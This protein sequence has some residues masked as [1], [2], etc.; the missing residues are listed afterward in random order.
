MGEGP[1]PRP[2]TP[3]HNKQYYV[4]ITHVRHVHLEQHE[5]LLV[6][7]LEGGEHVGVVL[8]PAPVHLGAGVQGELHGQHGV[9]AVSQG[10]HSCGGK[11]G[12][13]QVIQLHLARLEMRLPFFVNYSA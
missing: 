2:D 10:D 11:H 9:L 1:G 12:E 5:L 4:D 8:V 7:Q 13:E 6:R 3:G